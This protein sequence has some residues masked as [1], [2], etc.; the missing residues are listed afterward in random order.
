[1]SSPSCSATSFRS[2]IKYR[3]TCQMMGIILLEEIK[4][5]Y[6]FLRLDIPTQEFQ[7][8]KYLFF[9]TA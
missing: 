6:N 8:P 4:A 9:F 7:I 5:L 2:C 3:F 1:M